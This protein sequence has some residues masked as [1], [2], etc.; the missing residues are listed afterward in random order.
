MHQVN[1][2]IRSCFKPIRLHHKKKLIQL[3]KSQ[4][5]YNK[6]K[7]EIELIRNIVYHFL[8]YALLQEES[9]ALPYG[10]NHHILRKTNKILC[11]QNSNIFY[12]TS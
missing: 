12:R 3:R 10:L 7:T 1:I 11:E 9:N 5:N 4:Q 2:D 6:S 8:S